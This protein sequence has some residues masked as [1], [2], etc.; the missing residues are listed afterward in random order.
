MIY[1]S[2]EA[3]KGVENAE[4]FAPRMKIKQKQFNVKIAM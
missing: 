4:H 3:A 1:T 2:V